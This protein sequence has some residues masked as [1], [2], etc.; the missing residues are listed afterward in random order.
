L[1][2]SRSKGEYL[3]LSQTQQ[4]LMD[5]ERLALH[6][7][8]HDVFASVGLQKPP[9]ILFTELRFG[10]PA[11]EELWLASSALLWRE[12]YLA[13][14]A[15][16]HK[17]PSFMEAMQNPQLLTQHS[18]RVNVHLSSL[19]IL[20]G[21]WGQIHG[22][23]DAKKYHSRASSTHQLSIMATGNELYRDLSQFAARLPRL[24]NN[25][26]DT[27]LLSELFLMILH[28]NLE[29]LQ[30]FAGRFGEEEAVEATEEFRGWSKTMEARTAVWHAAQVIRA[31]KN[32]APNALMAFNAIAVYYATLTL[33]IY[34]LTAPPL[35]SWNDIQ[36]E[37]FQPHVHSHSL[38]IVL[39]EANEPESRAFRDNE[40]GL[41]G[42]VVFSSEGRE[43]IPL[44]K[45]DRILQFARRLYFDNY[46]VEEDPLP[47][48]VEGLCDLLK[49]L[50][51]LPSNRISRAQSENAT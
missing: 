22:L 5:Y 51:S 6:V 46:S 32:L 1:R 4:S 19:I 3:R 16:N 27:I 18:R 13:A 36:D 41:P 2:E 20:H 8:T 31:A 26:P 21:F 17:L 50:E 29:D 24:T 42:I 25:S 12:K 28:V 14:D 15:A 49:E 11:S 43:F 38:E 9:L 7:F 45:A 35:P 39:N 10:L 44:K 40:K 37:Q 47:P 48:L 30:R 23:L 34:G 33:W